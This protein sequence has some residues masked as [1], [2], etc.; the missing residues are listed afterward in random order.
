MNKMAAIAKIE[1][2][3]ITLLK[4]LGQFQSIFTGI[5]TALDLQKKKKKNNNKKTK[6]TKKKQKK[7]Q[8]KKKKH[9][10]KTTKN[11]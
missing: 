10:T 4:P 11:K 6:Q 8:K 2:K 5:L 7:K 9:T 1:K 3:S